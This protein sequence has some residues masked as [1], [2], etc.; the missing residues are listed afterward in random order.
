MK[1]ILKRSAFLFIALLASSLAF[2]EKDIKIKITGE[3]SKEN[4]VHLT[5]ASQDSKI[6]G[7]LKITTLNL[8][9][10]NES[11]RVLEGELEFPL[12]EGESVI[13]YAIDVNGRLREGVAVE[14]DKGRQ[15]F[16][17]VAR[18]GI[19]PGLVEKTA[20]NNFKTRVY[21]IPAKGIRQ[22]K[23]VTQGEVKNPE[24]IKSGV[25]TETIGKESWFYYS[26]PI[27][28]R[29]RA[30]TL[31]KNLTVWWDISG[32][33][34]NRNIDAEINFLKSYIKKLNEPKIAVYPFANELH[35]ARVF[36]IKSE[37]E[38][39]ALEEFLRSLEYDG[40]TNLSYDF[41]N[42]G[43]DEILVFTDGL[44]NWSDPYSRAQSGKKIPTSAI[45]SSASADHARLSSIA[46]KSGGLYVNLAE[47]LGYAQNDKNIEKA[48]ALFTSEPYRLIRADCDKA[49]V[50]ELYPADGTVVSDSFSLSG[51][52]KKK[53]AK[54]TLHFGYGNSIEESVVVNISAVDEIESDYIAREWAVKKIESL[55]ADYEK[56]RQEIIALAKKWT[57]VTK[58][59]S[60]IVLE[61]AQ[62]YARY[63]ITPPQSDK[64]L[65]VEYD[66]IVARQGSANFKPIDENAKGGIP[67]SVYRVFEEFKNWWNTSL[68]EFKKKKTK[69]DKGGIVR[70]LGAARNSQAAEEELSVEADAPMLE[71]MA[72][73]SVNI[74]SAAA[75]H[76][77][78]RAARTDSAN[79]SSSERAA[80]EGQSTATQSSIK[81]QAWSP[82]SDYLK[83]LKKTPTEKMYEKYLEL[84]KS[85][86][87][88]P[89]FYMEVSDYF[90][91]EGLQG[92]SVR[93]LSNLAELNLE[94]TDILRALANKLVER[95]MY[96]LAVPVFEKL[97]LLKGEV[98]Q[99][100]R[101]LGMAYH[102]CGEEQKAVDTLYSVAQKKWDSRFD[103]VQQIALNDM[104]AIIAEC[105]R[106]NIKLDTSALDKKLIE[107]FDVDVRIILTWNTDD[108]DV[109]LWVTDS[110]GEKCYYGNRI[111]ANG[112]RLSRDFTQ[113]YGPEEFCIKA[114]PKGALKIEANYFG[115]HQQKLLQPVTVQA[116][117]YTNFGRA[118]Q[119]RELLTLQL[120][121]V[122]GTFLIGE[123][124]F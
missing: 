55:S 109:D 87:A 80:K 89:A 103:Q 116:E 54:I 6:I 16:E 5:L 20:G 27:L 88:S 93:I 36:E 3:D 4:P 121:D 102:L 59:T 83:T 42:F 68:E 77:M 120:N 19:D 78:S 105:A 25:W 119:K 2:S 1:T 58:D 95:K 11:G 30:K 76:L 13:G 108:C 110:D 114:A 84:K 53:S 31:P 48:A 45:N 7:N 14:K 29:E 113:G 37:K 51:I 44:G 70:P 86:G 96:A 99:F 23:I 10:A 123:V 122:K 64:E 67:D 101:D 118:N 40:A 50:A 75:P 115:N 60:L 8:I 94:N 117:V 32:S 57:V 24:K 61:T 66:K 33:G 92:E 106:K 18:Q 82:D 63:G 97:V 124:E 47:I 39:A 104:N 56:N 49:E 90:A 112:A 17:A 9:V 100:Y 15:V 79:G 74:E 85:Y 91:E 22:I 72:V 62:D 38:L 26:R 43:G 46:Q 35:S 34:E 98:P 21:P 69:K 111:T 107:N 65:R 73:D 52:L 71:A 81:L 41:A 12:D 28:K